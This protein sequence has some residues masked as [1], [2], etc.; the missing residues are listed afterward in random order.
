MSGHPVDRFQHLYRELNRDRLHLL[1]DVYA[2]EVVFVDPVHRV[3]GLS[4]LTEYFR[5]MY[6]GVTDIGFDFEEVMAEDD[7]AFL[8]W[9]MRLR[10]A[11]FRPRETLVL[12]GASFVRFGQRIHFHRDYFDLGAMI[13]ERV[14]LLG[15]A[16]RTIK[17]RL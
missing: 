11:R 12:P 5:R 7:R 13:Y 1:A 8:T 3:E 14:P 2:P 6:E 4:A 15:G 9:T 16:V 17:N 10:H